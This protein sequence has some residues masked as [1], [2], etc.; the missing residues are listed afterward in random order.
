MIRL[1]FPSIDEEDHQAVISVLES[2]YLVQSSN[3]AAFE[4]AIAELVGTEYAI[5][6]SSCTAAL[7]ISL[8][9]LNVQPGDIVMVPAYSWIATANVVELCHARPCFVDILPETFNI[10]P[11][12]LN[13]TLD[14]IMADSMMAGKVKAIIP[15]HCFGQPAD[16][17]VLMSVADQFNIPVI[18]DAAC[19]LGAT[20][21]GKQAGAWGIAGCFS[22]HPRKAITTGEGGIITTNDTR[23][24]ERLRSLRNHGIRNANGSVDFI[25][26]GFNY[27]LTDFQ[28][29]LGVTQLQK[30]QRIIRSRRQQ[31]LY[32]DE[33]LQ[34]APLQTPKTIRGCESVHQSYVVLLPVSMREKRDALIAYLREKNI[35][36]TIG[37]INMPMTSF[38]SNRYGFA[39][40]TFPVTDDIS[41]R[42]LSLPLHEKLTTEDQRTV[43]YHLLQQIDGISP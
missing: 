10:D 14:R 5:A 2:G 42:S 11:A 35:E 9:S 20:L 34:G 19:A 31:S 26:P 23:L 41:S 33:L 1:S 16:M 13:S 18:E 25:M 36:T 15:V 7:H 40:G 32:Y 8:L 4:Q 39:P 22:F 28:G 37:T 17:P 3:V 43:A 6:V 27:R 29:A 24:A 30:L 38:F 21:H 12:A